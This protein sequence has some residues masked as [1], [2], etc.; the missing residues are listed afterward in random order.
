MLAIQGIEGMVPS[1]QVRVYRVS[2]DQ[3][4]DPKRSLTASEGV[5]NTDRRESATILFPHCK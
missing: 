4:T 1:L 5:S 2:A 3:N